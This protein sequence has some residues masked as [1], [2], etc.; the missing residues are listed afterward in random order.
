[1]ESWR[2]I[3]GP[4]AATPAGHAMCKISWACKSREVTCVHWSWLLQINTASLK[5]MHTSKEGLEE[6]RGQCSPQH[7]HL[8]MRTKHTSTQLYSA[9]Q[10]QLQCHTPGRPDRSG[11]QQSRLHCGLPW[12]LLARPCHAQTCA[13]G[14]SCFTSTGRD[15]A[16]LY[17][18][19]KLSSFPSA[20]RQQASKHCSAASA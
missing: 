16:E 3:V 14:T 9:T 15:L 6:Y 4:S 20:R 1:M 17:R 5:Q 19:L 12:T 13:G 7:I 18:T 11:C 10:H 2:G 8:W